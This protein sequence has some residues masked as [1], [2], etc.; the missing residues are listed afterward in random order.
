MARHELE[1]FVDWP[2]FTRDVNSELA[3]WISS[4]PICFGEGLPMVVLEAMTAGVPVVST[5]VEGIPEAIR[6]GLDGVIARPNDA[7]DLAQKIAR[8]VRW[9]ASTGPRCEPALPRSP[10]RKVFGSCDGPPALRQPVAAKCLSAQK[11]CTEGSPKGPI[12]I[13]LGLM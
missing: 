2:G 1:P 6:D 3:A 4:L 5:D 7:E 8:I 9:Q 12:I 13:V 11:S 10:R